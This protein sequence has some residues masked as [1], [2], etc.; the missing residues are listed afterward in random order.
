MGFQFTIKDGIFEMEG[1]TRPADVDEQLYLF[2]AKLANPGWDPNPVLRAKAA[3]KLS[4]QSLSANPLAVLNRDLDWLLDDRDPRY[5]TPTPAELDAAT[6]EGFRKVWEPLLKQGPVE[7]LVFGDIN[8]QQTIAALSRTFGALSKREPIPPEVLAR[9]L[10]FPAPQD[11]PLVLH[12]HGDKDQAAAVVAWPTGGGVAG[13]PTS[14]RLEVLGEIFS[15]R[16]LDAMR[17]KAGASYSPQVGSSWPDELDSGGRIVAMAQMPPAEVPE[18]FDAADRIAAG[19]AAKG[20]TED[21]LNRVTEPM[22]NL[23]NRALSGH[24][25]WMDMLEGSTADPRRIAALRTLMTDYTDVT[26]DDIKALAQQ[27]LVSRKGWRV[28]VI[29][30]GEQLATRPP[31]T[32]ASP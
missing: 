10:A 23:I 4:Y 12:H 1:E 9:G 11:A 31:G 27:Y 30:D 5:A 19:L 28:A 14:R 22:R 3:A 18:F 8:E 2:A 16:L 26:P 24:R 29:P 32:L 13:L 21:E 20:P 6:P 7:V 15:D 17:E 25:F